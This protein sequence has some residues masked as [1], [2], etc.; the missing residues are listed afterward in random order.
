MATEDSKRYSELCKEIAQI[1]YQMG[2]IKAKYIK[3]IWTDDTYNTRDS[4][5]VLRKAELTLRLDKDTKYKSLQYKVWG[6]CAER[7]AILDLML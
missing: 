3:V 4:K 7:T 2:V 5:D 6:F 1:D